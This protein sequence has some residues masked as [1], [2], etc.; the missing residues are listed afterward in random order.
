[1]TVAA[2]RQ[3]MV[4][5]PGVIRA[6]TLRVSYSPVGIVRADKPFLLQLPPA[7]KYVFRYA[8]SSGKGDW[9][10]AK[11]YRM[12]RAFSNPLVAV[13]ALDELS[14]KQLPPVHSFCSLAGGNLV[15]S[16][17]KKAERDGAIVLR[18][19]EA[20]GAAAQ[21]P[22]EFLGRKRSFRLANLLEE[23]AGQSEQSL[24]R[25][26]PHQISTLRMRTE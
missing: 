1:V 19:F 11:S 13:S 9:A 12:G 14:N 3:W 26:S 21:T 15:V 23:S 6:G 10:A 2:D 4:L 18:V 20:E 24:L 8:L 22:V 25:V 17:V 5:E 16:A 7:G